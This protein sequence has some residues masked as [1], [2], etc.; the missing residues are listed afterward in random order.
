MTTIRRQYSLPNCTLILEGLSDGTTPA[1]S[2]ID[3]RPLMTM[4]VNAECSFNGQEQSLSGGRDF[5][6]SLVRSVSR[7]A[8]EFLS[9]IPHP[10]LPGEPP[11]LVYFQK[12][13]DKNLHRLTLQPSA[14]PILAGTG[15]GMLHDSVSHSAIAQGKQ[16]QMDLTTVQ[17]F[18]LVEAIDQFLADRRTLPD[19]GVALEPVPRRYRRADQPVAKR[20]APAALGITS[21]AVAAIAFLVVP[22]P[23]VRDPKPSTPQPSSSTTSSPTPDGQR[24]ANT[25]PKA[26]PPP[27]SELEKVLTAAPEITDPTELRFLQRRLYNKLDP[28]WKNRG[29][30][31]QSLEYRVGVGKD[32]AIVGYK[33][34]NELAGGD[35]ATKTP[36]PD[37]L[38]IPATGSVATSEPIAQFRVVFSNRGIL[39]IS[40]WR[41]YTG[42]PTL[43]PE[44][45]DATVIK[46]VND[47]LYNQIR[48]NWKGTLTFPRDLTYRVAATKDAV[49]VDYEPTNQPGWD[50]VDQ[51]PLNSLIKPQT[52]G[53]GS[54]K[55]EALPQEPLAQFRVVFK[56]GGTFEVSPFQGYR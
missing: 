41:G 28:E 27:A 46:D 42:K 6:E 54:E 33:P 10:K 25:T 31:S 22:I 36:L 35:A 23:Q 38:Y 37:L 9:Q 32:G 52:P 53:S 49:I 47:K 7:Y 19:I 21:L 40:P 20:A 26:S 8:Q 18:D 48:E 12:L 24:Q 50:Y 43:G 34:V 3:S 5:F 17:L 15:A 16:V 55:A 13:K 4:L 45:T 2:Q 1:G 44:L 11:E 51:T 56:N 29:Q 14:D 39:Q 30:L